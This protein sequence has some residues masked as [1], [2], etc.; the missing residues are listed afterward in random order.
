MLG[1]VKH[2]GDLLSAESEYIAQ[3]EDGALLRRQMLK[4]DDK[5]QRDRFLG[6]HK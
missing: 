2:L 3:H 6:H 5:R 1:G 4:A